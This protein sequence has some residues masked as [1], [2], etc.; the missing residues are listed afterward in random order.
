MLPPPSSVVHKFPGPI[1]SSSVS[2]DPIWPGPKVEKAG[3]WGLLSGP[4][5]G[6]LT[7]QGSEWIHMSA[8]M[9]WRHGGLLSLP[10]LHLGLLSGQSGPGLVPGL[11]PGARPWQPARVPHYLPGS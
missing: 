2:W 7:F 11:P 5:R 8:V 1:F 4:Q 9:V 10:D 3:A 6:S